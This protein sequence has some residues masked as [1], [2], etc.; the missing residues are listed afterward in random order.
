[1]KKHENW[2]KQSIY[3]L[4]A[5]KWD[6]EGGF[7]S[8]A[9]FKAQQAAELALKGYCVAK[10]IAYDKCHSVREA[11]LLAA[12][13]PREKWGCARGEDLYEIAK[14]NKGMLNF[15]A[16][17]ERLDRFYMVSRYPDTLPAGIPAD[18]FSRQDAM[19]AYK[20]A[21]LIVHK[22]LRDLNL[23]YMLDCDKGLGL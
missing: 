20:D 5:S 16:Q 13:V 14:G 12:R 4:A 9:C 7:H 8:W 18:F 11:I 22:V 6:L 19:E 10:H 21:R 15:M 1:M 17:A 23:T 2:V 3:T